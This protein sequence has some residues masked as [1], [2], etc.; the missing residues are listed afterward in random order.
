MVRRH[1][2]ASPAVFLFIII[3]LAILGSAQASHEITPGQGAIDQLFVL[4]FVLALIIG[5][6]VEGLLIAAI[7]LFR[8][9]PG[10]HLPTRVTTHNPRL[11]FLWTA[12]PVLVIAII[13]AATFQTLLITD[14][15]PQETMTVQVIGE[16]FSFSF[17]YPDNT[18]SE[19]LLR[20]Q[21]G[22]VVRLEVTSTD[23]I[24]SYFIPDF[25]L[26]IDAVPGRVNQYW[27]QALQVGTYVIRCAEY[28]GVGHFTMTATLEVFPAGS[29][30]VPWGPPA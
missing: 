25:R 18:T 5:I 8:R 2:P 16:R 11:E 10:F 29:Q 4:V 3:G 13:G 27:F 14:T 1:H 7:I 28:C 23:V 24:H 21:E 30:P 20:V 9:R 15:I 12:L 26:K 19:G 17:I 22:E 6:V